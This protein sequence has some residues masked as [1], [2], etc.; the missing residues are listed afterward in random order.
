MLNHLLKRC[1]G[2]TQ[3][4]RDLAFLHMQHNGP[5]KPKKQTTSNQID[6]QDTGR[7]QPP[8]A[9]G[10][11]HGL[12]QQALPSDL[13]AFNR[14]QIPSLSHQVAQGGQPASEPFQRLMQRQKSALDTLAEV[15]HRHMNYSANAHEY[16][17]VVQ[18]PTTARQP[19]RGLVENQLLA[20][21]QRQDAG[22]NGVARSVEPTTLPMYPTYISQAQTLAEETT[23]PDV[24]VSLPLVNTAT[25]ATHHMDREQLQRNDAP[26]DPRLDEAVCDEE[27]V[28]AAPNHETSRQNQ[29]GFISW[30][31]APQDFVTQQE[32]PSTEPNPEFGTK[33]KIDRS[34]ARA[35]FTDTRRKEV[36]EIRKRGA[37][38]RCRMLK[39]P[40]SDGNPCNTCKKIDSARLWKGT[41]LRTK[42][43]EEFTVY[44]ASWFQ[45]TMA[46]KLSDSIQALDC[47]SL[48]GRIEIKFLRRSTLGM[49]FGAKRYSRSTPTRRTDHNFI[50]TAQS[51]HNDEI[52]VL[53]DGMASQRV[54]QKV[55]AYCM[56]D[57][58]LQDCVGSEES[59]FMQATIGE[60]MTLLASETMRETPSNTQPSSRTNH[61]SPNVL[62]SN[63]IELW[64]ETNLLVSQGRDVF[65][66]RYNPDIPSSPGSQIVEW[67]DNA[68]QR[69]LSSKSVSYSLICSQIRA[70]TETACRELSKAVM[71]ELE[72]RLL[73][74]QQVSSFATFI[75]AV[76]LLNCIE[77][78]S[79]FYHSLDL[80]SSLST[81]T[82]DATTSAT[83]SDLDSRLLWYPLAAVLSSTLP[84]QGP[85]F[86]RIL[87]TL[88]HMRALPPK[89]TLTADNKLAV[90]QEPVLPVRLNG[91]AVRGQR[92]AETSRAA[93]WLDPLRLDVDELR[94]RRDDENPG[95]NWD[96]RF[97]SAVLLGEG[98]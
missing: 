24:P 91:V 22:E 43:A 88:L 18:Y 40:C 41:C 96:M 85:H 61:I 10:A 5:T 25:A 67:T 20:A 29:D 89:T 53:D 83:Q 35:R 86:A 11:S 36:Q 32:P 73:Q 4:D 15:S 31:E 21:L 1:S 78:I 63:V 82:K 93:E 84:L 23:F 66:I 71:N 77:R 27:P 28:L 17:N 19:D 9:V 45:S 37:C 72:R 90:L 98:M 8:M 7:Y 59:S 44:S 38:M 97:I 80:T 39:K 2:M 92:D 49:T 48:P 55:S 3:D 34:N 16:T 60:A 65:E 13:V 62:L 26:I 54:S 94:A 51:S 79:S 30:T 42:L 70:A 33:Q 75:S 50:D 52:I 46:K 57:R 68:S 58:I 14:H 64:V 47:A 87:T 76:V 95:A 56:N 12:S 74:R 69:P 81:G 6:Q